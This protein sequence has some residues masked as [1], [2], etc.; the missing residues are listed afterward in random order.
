MIAS[1]SPGIRESVV[2]G[3][4]GFL[5]Q[6][7]DVPAMAEAMRKLAQS[8][9]L[10]EMLGKAGRSFAEKFSWDRSA[11]DTISHLEGVVMGEKHQW[12]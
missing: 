1:D 6:H 10:V 11:D 9:S 5:T 4:T 2:D 12:R 3:E 7:G 8:P